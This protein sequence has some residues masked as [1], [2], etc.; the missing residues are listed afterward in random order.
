MKIRSKNTRSPGAKRN[1]TDFLLGMLGLA[2]AVASLYFP[3]H[4]YHNEDAVV[5][6]RLEFS[7]RGDLYGEP[8]DRIS[9]GARGFVSPVA[10]KLLDPVVTGSVAESEVTDQSEDEGEDAVSSV[11]LPGYRVLY[12]A[13]GLALV[14]DRNSVFIVGKG[15]PLPAGGKVK[16]IR[17]VEGS[18]QIR[19]SNGDLI[20]GP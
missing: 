16:S 3:W 1:L 20:A 15:A 12:S 2:L 14:R 19:A 4:V 13:N 18:W 17:R 7:G 6:P 10:G 9:V 11:A 5:L 8:E